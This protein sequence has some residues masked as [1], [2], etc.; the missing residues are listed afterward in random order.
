[1]AESGQ[2]ENGKKSRFVKT[3]LRVAGV[4]IALAGVVLTVIG[5]YFFYKQDD[6]LQFAAFIG[7][8]LII[9][10]MFLVLFSFQRELSRYKKGEGSGMFGSATTEGS[11]YVAASEERSVVVCECGT[12]NDSAAKFCKKCGKPLHSVCPFCGNEIDV[13][14]DF[15]E[16][17]GKALSDK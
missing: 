10:G 2:T 4:L 8:S 12:V 11:S 14:S 3:G 6:N 13:D 17:C 1:M 5:F 15:C 16:N 9:V 7:V